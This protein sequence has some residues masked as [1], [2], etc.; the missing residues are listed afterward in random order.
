MLAARG[1]QSGLSSALV[2]IRTPCGTG[3]YILKLAIFG[4]CV[5]RDVITHLPPSVDLVSYIARSSLVSASHNTAYQGQT[6]IP[7]SVS[8]FEERMIRHDLEKTGLRTLLDSKPDVVLVDLIDERFRVYRLGDSVVTLS[9]NLV[10]EPLGVEMRREGTLILRD[11]LFEEAFSQC[12]TLFVERLSPA[13]EMRILINEAYWAETF[14]CDGEISTFKNLDEIRENNRLLRRYYDVFRR[15]I[16]KKNFISFDGPLH[17][18]PNHIWKLSPFHY[19]Q[20][21]YEF[22]ASRII[23]IDVEAGPR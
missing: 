22:L 16:P 3:R 6:G 13:G 1:L 23:G 18:D 8:R 7:E 4:S 14:I 20:D 10:Y 5:S 11:E 2:V 17:A 21:F 9:A 12:A 15:L 19:T